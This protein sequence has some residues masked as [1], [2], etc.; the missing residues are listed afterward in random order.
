[1]DNAA[2][3]L[4]QSL[5]QKGI[6]ILIGFKLIFFICQSIVSLAYPVDFAHG[7]VAAGIFKRHT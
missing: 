4:R 6:D 7:P 2:N 5:G 3:R 1:M